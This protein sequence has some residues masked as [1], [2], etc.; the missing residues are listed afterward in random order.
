MSKILSPVISEKSMNDASKGR[1]TFR[2]SKDA[3]KMELKREIEERFKVNIVK[4]STMNIKGRSLRAGVRR[5]EIALS[6]FKKAI[7]LV[8]PGQKIAMFDIGGKE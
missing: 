1:Y 2:V 5:A 8:K 4:I 7:V 3:T 6:S